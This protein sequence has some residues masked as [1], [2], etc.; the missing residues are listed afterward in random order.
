MNIVKSL[1]KYYL[2]NWDSTTV[3][4]PVN[5]RA[6]SKMSLDIIPATLATTGRAAD[7]VVNGGDVKVLPLYQKQHCHDG[8]W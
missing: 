7:T 4:L 3:L 2:T 8:G 5:K 1:S 6:R